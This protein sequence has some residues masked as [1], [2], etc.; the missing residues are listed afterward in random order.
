MPDDGPSL[1]P[2]F[3]A[4]LE[5]LIAE[6]EQ[7][8]DA[9]SKSSTPD[10]SQ[11]S[12]TGKDR[13]EKTG[14]PTTRKSGNALSPSV[15]LPEMLQKIEQ[16]LA[17]H[18]ALPTLMN[19]VKAAVERKN[20]VNKAMFDALHVELKSYKDTFILEA[21]LKPVI[22][23]LI[24]IYDDAFDIHKHL[25]AM[26]VSLESVERPDA[27]KPV[28]S[29]I[30]NSVTRTEH[31]VHFLIEVLERLDVTQMPLSTG[32]LDKLTQRAVAVES[33]EDSS[34]DQTIIR[35]VKCGF[36]WR[37]RV[38]RPEEVVIKKWLPPQSETTPQGEMMAI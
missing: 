33:T 4:Q 15:V 2:E 10:H 8:M 38:F 13:S 27:L 5:A 14:T 34:E 22:H 26:L 32:K 29:K 18:E 7:Q 3:T 1:E 35:T 12:D 9:K 19:E 11:E 36:I 17:S 28:S 23:D 6:A 30:K 37:D 31:H 20:A 25:N 21:V 16:V 24:V